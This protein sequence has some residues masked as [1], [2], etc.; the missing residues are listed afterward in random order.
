MVVGEE[1]SE[2]SVNLMA[3]PEGSEL[4]FHLAGETK[5]ALALDPRGAIR[6]GPPK[7]CRTAGKAV[8]VPKILLERNPLTG[9]IIWQR[10]IGDGQG[11]LRSR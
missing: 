9:P 10:D 11:K 4:S 6:F 5:A 1:S 7:P 3:S 8:P 2:P